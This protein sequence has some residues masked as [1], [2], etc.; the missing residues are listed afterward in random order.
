M[1]LFLRARKFV[2]MK[3][4]SL[5]DASDPVNRAVK[6]VFFCFLFAN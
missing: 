2:T 1:S 6:I 5:P 3:N 4:D